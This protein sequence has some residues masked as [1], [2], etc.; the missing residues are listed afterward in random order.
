MIENIVPQIKK[1]EIFV[2]KLHSR[3]TENLS[4]M[5]KFL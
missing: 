3:Y 1:G 5:E 2:N 4:G